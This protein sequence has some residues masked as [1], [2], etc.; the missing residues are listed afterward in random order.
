MVGAG[1]P[2]CCSA[3]RGAIAVVVAADA[4]A[5]VFEGALGLPAGLFAGAPCAEAEAPAEA[6]L[7]A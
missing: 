3:V 6:G 4:S 7:S 1:V 5:G 2:V